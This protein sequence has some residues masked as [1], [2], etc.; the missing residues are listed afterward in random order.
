M[1][2]LWTVDSGE[3]LSRII[4]VIMACTADTLDCQ[5]PRCYLLTVEEVTECA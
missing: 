4:A 1:K 5:N 2:K 3:D